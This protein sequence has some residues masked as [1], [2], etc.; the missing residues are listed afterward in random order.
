MT[1]STAVNS[2]QYTGDGATSSYAYTFR[3]FDETELVV[4]ELDTS[5]NE[6]VYTLTTDYT[7]DA[8]TIGDAGGG[9]IALVAGNLTANYELEIKRVLPLTQATDIRNNDIYLPEDIEDQFDRL[10]MID[11][12]QQ[13]TLDRS[14]VLPTTVSGVSLEL[15]TP[16]AGAALAW[17]S[18]EDALENITVVASGTIALP[19]TSGV[20]CYT[21]ANTFTARVLTAGAGMAITNPRGVGGN[22]TFTVDAS[23]VV[24]T[25]I[26][27]DVAGTGLVLGAGGAGIQV[28]PDSSTGATH[29]PVT[30]LAGSGTSVQVDNSTITHAAGVLSVGVILPANVDLTDDYAFSGDLDATT[31]TAGDNSSSVATTAF[32]ATAVADMFYTLNKEVGAPTTLGHGVSGTLAS[33]AVGADLLGSAGMIVIESL[34][35]VQT[36]SSASSVEIGVTYGG[37]Y[38]G[39]ASSSPAG[40]HAEYPICF[41][42]VI[43][44][45]DN[46]AS[47][48][49][50]LSFLNRHPLAAEDAAVTAGGTTTTDATASQGLQINK[51]GTD[52]VLKMYNT[53]VFIA[54]PVV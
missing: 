42:A 14:M 13:D 34:I 39:I 18:A 5:G 25:M 54:K 26:N 19:A 35:T 3:I 37:N 17:N 47:Q 1:V 30:I 33:C 24:A 4:T 45:Q 20:S 21:A 23:G 29:C 22:P 16:S 32:V 38:V 48:R 12:Q 36:T 8:A 51:T 46:T 11:Q 28:N 44:G 10:I 27:G 9:T 7:V 41:R 52:A 50:E 53:R 2:V 6:T 43:S 15:P 49:G 40:I 31:Q